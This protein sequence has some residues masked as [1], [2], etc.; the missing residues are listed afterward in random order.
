LQFAYE[1]AT[2]AWQD[3]MES[4][5]QAE[6]DAYA[7]GLTN[8]Y[9]CPTYGEARR[10]AWAADPGQ[11]FFYKGTKLADYVA[12]SVRGVAGDV[13]MMAYFA[14]SPQDNPERLWQGTLLNEMFGNPFRPVAFDPAWRSDTA[15]PLAKHIYE[16]RDFSAMPILADALQD[17]GCEREA[18]L[19]HCRD[20]QQVHVRGCWVVD[21]VLGKE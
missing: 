19:A 1:E 7:A 14:V 15:V 13:A 3:A 6:R 9:T 21:L 17:A 20:P 2:K 16:A 8:K 12:A 4:A 11:Y 5:D 10:K 18:V